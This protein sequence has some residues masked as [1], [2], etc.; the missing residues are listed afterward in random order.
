MTKQQLK[1]IENAI[2]LLQKDGGRITSA[3]KMIL[4]I[5]A[6][7][8]TPLQAK[9]IMNLIKKQKSQDNIDLASIYRSLESFLELGIVHQIGPNSSYL[10]CLHI[11]CQQHLHCLVQ[12][13]SCN[14]TLEFDGDESLLKDLKQILK[15]MSTAIS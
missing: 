15:N 7:S 1:Y 12:C 5:L 8:E 4:N 3:R 13:T 10:P 14:K 6:V 11:H 2:A 9:D